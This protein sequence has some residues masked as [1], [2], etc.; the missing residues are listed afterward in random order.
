MFSIKKKKIQEQTLWNQFRGSKE[1][2]RHP[3]L[4]QLVGDW[5]AVLQGSIFK[6]AEP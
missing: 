4:G 1:D 6:V 5:P 2:K 3:G